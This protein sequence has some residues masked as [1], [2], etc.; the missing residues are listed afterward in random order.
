MFDLG[1]QEL[2]VIFIVALLVFGPKRLPELGKTLG[3][4]MKELKK[5]MFDIKNEFD[6]KSEIDEEMA[7]TYKAIETLHEPVGGAQKQND[8]AHEGEENKRASPEGVPPEG[9]GKR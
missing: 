7:K 8:A 4:G 3:R 1:V 2:V 6:V 5:A 9:E